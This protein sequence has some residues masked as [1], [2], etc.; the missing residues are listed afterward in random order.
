MSMDFLG[1]E[2]WYNSN[3]IHLIAILSKL[4]SES[5]FAD[6]KVQLR[7]ANKNKMKK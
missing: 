7:V 4:I 6:I 1:R 2:N 5:I 3:R